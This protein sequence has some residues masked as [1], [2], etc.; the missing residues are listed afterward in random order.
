[1]KPPATKGPPELSPRDLTPKD[2]VHT[3]ASRQVE[4]CDV[5]QIC[6]G[7]EIKTPSSK[8]LI[9]KVI[10]PMKELYGAFSLC[11][12]GDTKFKRLVYKPEYRTQVTHHAV[13]GDLD[14]VLF[15]VESK[16]IFQYATLSYFPRHKRLT[17]LGIL[18]G[19]YGRCLR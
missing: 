14:Y 6:C 19:V 16:T 10:N 2:G 5:E 15:V 13:T 1:M 12:F 7:L 11:E 9:D 4:V 3:T 17:F 8:K 18:K